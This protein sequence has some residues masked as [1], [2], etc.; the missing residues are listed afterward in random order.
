MK[1]NQNLIKRRGR[2]KLN[3]LNELP[4]INALKISIASCDKKSVQKLSIIMAVT[5]HTTICEVE[6]LFSKILHS[7]DEQLF[8]RERSAKLSLIFSDDTDFQT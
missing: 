8:K 3:S 4:I 5:V 7:S 2:G 6:W 1:N